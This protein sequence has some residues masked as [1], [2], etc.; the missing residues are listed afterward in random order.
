MAASNES[1]ALKIA[2]AV[3][4]TLVVILAVSTYFGYSYYAEA[5]AKLT[6]AT[7]KMQKQ[8]SELDKAVREMDEQRKQLGYEKTTDYAEVQNALKKDAQKLNEQLSAMANKV[9]ESIDKYKQDGGNSDKVTDLN[10]QL[11]QLVSQIT[12]EPNRTS[13]STISRETE[14]LDN[15]AQLTTELSLDNEALRK[16]LTTVNGVNAGQVGEAMA[17]ARK[18]A[19]EREGE[20]KKH[21]QERAS[22]MQKHDLLATQNN[23]QA[24]QISKL[25]QQIAQMDED[26]RK[27]EETLTMQV[28]DWRE[29]AEK[30]EVVLD[31]ADGRITFVDYTRNEVRTNITRSMGAKEQ[32]EFA[33]FDRKSPGLPTDT[34]KA[35]IQLIQ[36]GQQSSVARILKTVKTHDPIRLND[37]VYSAAWSPSTNERFA[38]IGK[39]DID[40]DGRDDREDLKRM[41]RA[42][43]GVIDYDLPP[44]GIGSETGAITP[45]T[46]WYVLDERDPLHPP[47]ET[48]RRRQGDD[49]ATFLA[50]RTEAIRTARQDGVRPMSIQRVLAYL[51]YSFG[52]AVPGRVERINR[53]AANNILNPRGLSTAPIPA[54]TS[55]A[56]EK[57]EAEPADDTKKDEAKPDEE[58]KDEDMP[59]DENP[60]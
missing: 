41:I 33:V 19:E 4:V 24:T 14:L 6:D 8:Q 59:K 54:A 12:N 2:V 35:T 21:E 28:R 13:A 44:A 60:K 29:R 40:R 34:P 36:V 9:K 17:A 30:N 46:S 38:L 56:E 47:G 22:I 53:E 39:I 45:Q 27:K 55:G 25:K 49:D 51:G 43:G 15:L 31:K 32:M 48:A 5:D 58:K 42:A 10:N 37:Q 3:L 26:H 16:Q 1:Q 20:A 18:A 7:G 52:E 23:E 57:K 11:D 50:K